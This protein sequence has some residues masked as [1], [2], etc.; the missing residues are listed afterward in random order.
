MGE[1]YV[2]GNIFM[3]SGVHV[4]GRYAMGILFPEPACWNTEA[5]TACLVFVAS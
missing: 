4:D 2:D 1:W 5:E 3:K